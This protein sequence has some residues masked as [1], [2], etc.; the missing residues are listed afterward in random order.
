MPD[1]FNIKQEL[2]YIREK[3]EKIETTLEKN[4]VTQDEFKPVQKIAWMLLT[5]VVG[6]AIGL[7]F[8]LGRSMQ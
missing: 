5:L 1:E 6:S 4:Y 8:Y 3:V 7:M 2:K